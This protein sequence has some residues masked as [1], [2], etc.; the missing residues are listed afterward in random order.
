MNTSLTT[1]DFHG[2]TLIA[3][4]GATPAETLVAMK[5]VAEGMGLDWASQFVK[6]KEHPVL[7]KG[8]GIITIPT[9]GG[10]QQMTALPL[11][12]LSFWLATIHPNKVPDEDTRARVI[13]YQMECADALFAHF[14]AKATE[15][16]RFRLPDG[17]V[18][19]FQAEHY[20]RI[21]PDALDMLEELFGS[22]TLDE[23]LA[24]VAKAL[25]DDA[26]P[27]RSAAG[28]FWR[29]LRQQS[30]SSPNGAQE[31][32]VPTGYVRLN[33]NLVV[34]L[35]KARRILATTE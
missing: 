12:R 9:D 17:A 18:K 3:Q 25:G 15:Q 2:A 23:A 33:L 5:P 34:P 16:P 6:I 21:S 1:V 35:D 20:S 27:S 4:R 29:F 24:E 19:R 30:R 14:F 13:A 10:I 31:E 28:R 11:S 7:S 32:P 22:C 26:C 8:V